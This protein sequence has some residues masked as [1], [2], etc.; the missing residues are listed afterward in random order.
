MSD[1]VGAICP[2]DEQ[3]PPG[4]TCFSRVLGTEK[5]RGNEDYGI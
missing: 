2:P 5:P 1:K 4:I 3:V